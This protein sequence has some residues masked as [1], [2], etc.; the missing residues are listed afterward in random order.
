MLWCSDEDRRYQGRCKAVISPRQ[1]RVF[2]FIKGYIDSN[3]KS[4]TIKEICEYFQYR[5]WATVHR[6]IVILEN[7]GLIKRTPLIARGLEIVNQ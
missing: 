2:Q 7:E 5:S 3:G 6:I 1:K 4:P